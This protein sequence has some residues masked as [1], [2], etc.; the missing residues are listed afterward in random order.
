MVFSRADYTSGL[1]VTIPAK[2]DYEE[3]FSI[4]HNHAVDM[5]RHMAQS[6]VVTMEFG[7]ISI[8]EAKTGLSTKYPTTPP[9]KSKPIVPSKWGKT[10]AFNGDSLAYQNISRLN[11]ES[12]F[13]AGK[14]VLEMAHGHLYFGSASTPGMYVFRGKDQQEVPDFTVPL[15]FAEVVGWWINKNPDVEVSAYITDTHVKISVGEDFFYTAKYGYKAYVGEK[16]LLKT[17]M[18][19]V[20][21][22]KVPSLQWSGVAPSGHH[23]EASVLV[24]SGVLSMSTVNVDGIPSR[25]DTPVEESLPF[26]VA[27][28]R[29]V[30]GTALALLGD[31][32]ATMIVPSSG[33]AVVFETSKAEVLVPAKIKLGKRKND[34]GSTE[35]SA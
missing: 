31:E 8:F 27:F 9:T 33:S 3:Y 15:S 30:L 28:A 17:R 11:K 7:S 21:E 1:Q 12:S 19:K 5:A 4:R 35:G 18:K 10:Y 16:A 24:K 22:L 26:E 6:A 29:S 34:S 20:A 23:S 25:I 2:S 32:E 13:M 14:P